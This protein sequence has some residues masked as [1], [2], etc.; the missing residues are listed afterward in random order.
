VFTIKLYSE[1]DCRL[2]I[3]SAESFTILRGKDDEGGEAEITLHQKNQSDDM[4]VDIKHE[5]NPPGWP[6]TFAKAIIENA[7]GRTTEIIAL[8]PN[9]NR[10]VHE[11]TPKAA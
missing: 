8:G 5:P 9:P 7:Q 10:V 2:V 1:N 3:K 6:R 4:R 11:Q